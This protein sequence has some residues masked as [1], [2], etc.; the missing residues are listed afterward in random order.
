VAARAW[1]IEARLMADVEAGRV[2][3]RSWFEDNQL[4]V[5]ANDEGQT[6]I[7]GGLYP[8]AVLRPRK[9]QILPGREAQE[10]LTTVRSGGEI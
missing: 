8:L 9:R 7:R 4:R 1:Q 3:L 6:V 10:D 5:A 2:E